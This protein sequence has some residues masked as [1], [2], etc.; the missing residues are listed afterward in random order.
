MKPVCSDFDTFTVGSKG[1]R[2]APTPSK[3]LELVTWSLEHGRG[4]GE[5][6]LRVVRALSPRATRML[7]E[8]TYA[9]ASVDEAA[10]HWASALRAPPSAGGDAAPSGAR[11][12]SSSSA[13]CA[14]AREPSR[15]CS[16]TAVRS[17]AFEHGDGSGGRP[18]INP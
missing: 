18:A 5:R 7:L 14:A 15:S 13:A 8:Y 2:Y 1:M 17:L 16:R 4:V 10:L 12:A 6:A 3:Q 9:D 11:E